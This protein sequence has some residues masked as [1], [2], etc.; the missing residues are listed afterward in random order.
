M[1]AFRIMGLSGLLGLVAVVARE[2]PPGAVVTPDEAARITGGSL[3]SHDFLLNSTS[4]SYCTGSKYPN[5]GG[6]AC[7]INPFYQVNALPGNRDNDTS[8]SC[9]EKQCNGQT[10][11][12]GSATDNV[13]T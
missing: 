6:G 9:S 12:C 1:R 2:G 10:V 11:K 4:V 13:C 7:G 8:A 5:C 3:G